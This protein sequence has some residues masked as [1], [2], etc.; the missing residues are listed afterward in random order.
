M[1]TE[2]HLFELCSVLIPCPVNKQNWSNFQKI[3]SV[4]LKYLKCPVLGLNSDQPVDPHTPSST[5]WMSLLSNQSCTV[6]WRSSLGLV[7]DIVLRIWP[8]C[9]VFYFAVWYIGYWEIA[10]CASGW[11]T[12]PKGVVSSDKRETNAVG[13]NYLCILIFLFYLF[14]F[15]KTTPTA[16]ETWHSALWTLYAVT[17][18]ENKQKLHSICFF[19]KKKYVGGMQKKYELLQQVKTFVLFQRIFF[20]S[21][22]SYKML[23]NI[24]CSKN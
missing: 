14:C 16:T 13:I 23:E 3:R 22:N 1:N 2:Q 5:K 4:R 7:P 24:S 21:G 8:A 17:D 20:M 15:A 9:S 11:H 6:S 18:R 10:V 19:V 12:V